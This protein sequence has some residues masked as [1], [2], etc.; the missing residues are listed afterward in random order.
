LRFPVKRR[1]RPI[2]RNSA[3]LKRRETAGQGGVTRL[4]YFL[5][6][7]NIGSARIIGTTLGDISVRKQFRRKGYGTEIL[8]DLE[9]RGVASAYVVNEEGEAFFEKAG[10]VHQGNGRWTKPAENDG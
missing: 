6:S 8:K 4:T 10:W 2:T 7:V 3:G 1:N 9:K 5:D